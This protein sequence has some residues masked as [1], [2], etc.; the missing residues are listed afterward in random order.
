VPYKILAL[1][2]IKEVKD[3]K[4]GVQITGTNTM[5][6][7]QHHPSPVELRLRVGPCTL[8]EKKKEI[9]NMGLSP[10]L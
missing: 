6:E 5:D 1:T 8:G 10:P 9:G 2:K 4:R 7:T 3:M